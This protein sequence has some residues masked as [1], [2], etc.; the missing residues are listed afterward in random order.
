MNDKSD[1]FNKIEVKMYSLAYVLRC[2]NFIL[3]NFTLPLNSLRLILR[4]AESSY[5]YLNKKV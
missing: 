1:T 2:I 4:N 5:I 3:L